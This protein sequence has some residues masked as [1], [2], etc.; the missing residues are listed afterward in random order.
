MFYC[1]YAA[2]AYIE[3]S[4][5]RGLMTDRARIE[6]IERGKRLRALREQIGLSRSQFSNEV[7]ISEHT[8]KS[9]ELGARELS[10]QKAREYS[11]IFLFA[12]ID[13]SF[14]YLYY[15]KEPESPTKKETVTKDNINIQ[16]E[17]IF[18]KKNNP[19]SIIYKIQDSLMAPF[20]N[21][22][23]IVGGQ[24]TTNEKQFVYFNGHVC[25]IEG[26][27]GNQCLRRVIKSE[28]RKVIVCT[29]NT[30]NHQNLP[31]IEEI[32]AFSIAQATRHWRLSELVETP[33]VDI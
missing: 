23:D 1:K 17:I 26:T 31:I 18:F 30:E 6:A 15:G 24:K 28:Y 32:D 2:S 14:D 29:L 21:K 9:F 16:S 22:G 10:I 12:G 20:Y 5:Y 4:F 25:V 8:L 3:E 33:C 13:V 11:K 19:S 27:N 7:N